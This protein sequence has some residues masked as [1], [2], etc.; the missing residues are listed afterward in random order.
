MIEDEMNKPRGESSLP[1][2]Q[3]YR[4]ETLSDL[5]SH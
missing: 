4:P 1:W 3:K 5:I 2:V